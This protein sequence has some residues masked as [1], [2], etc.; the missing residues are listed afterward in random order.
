M[1][2]H[3]RGGA[4]IAALA[5][6]A[7]LGHALLPKESD[8]SSS[9]NETQAHR[10][11]ADKNGADKNSLGA[12]FS[13]LSRQVR[14]YD[15]RPS[16]ARVAPPERFMGWDATR[17]ASHPAWLLA[18][19]L[20]SGPGLPSAAGVG[21]V[22]WSFLAPGGG[23]D[24]SGLGS[25][26]GY[27]L[28]GPSVGAFGGAALWSGLQGAPARTV[29]ASGL[30]EQSSRARQAQAS[31][32]TE[33]VRR[34]G[35]AREQSRDQWRS[36]L[37]S[38]LRDE[39][40]LARRVDPGLLEPYV[41]TP[42]QAA[43]LIN[44]RL[45]L[46][47]TLGTS[48]A[49]KADAQSERL[50]LENEIRSLLREQELARRGVLDRLRDVLPAQLEAKRRDELATFL[51]ELDAREGTALLPLVEQ[52]RERIARDFGPTSRL[53]IVL[54]AIAA[55]PEAQRN[56][57][58]SAAGSPSTRG[59][60]GFTGSGQWARSIEESGQGSVSLSREQASF[61]DLGSSDASARARDLARADANQWERVARRRQQAWKKLGSGGTQTRPAGSA[62][63][64]GI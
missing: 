29:L 32:L 8:L 34:A 35:L 36:S 41:P 18:S 38:A 23:V 11:G 12:W 40:E 50:A 42:E 64:K 22:D 24:I 57:S 31:A 52:Q 56:S 53:G 54:P 60:S 45:R 63:A 25:S 27:T 20:D 30:E 21:A 7:A 5:L 16:A 3:A 6:A 55:L 19:R 33:F 59:G 58:G 61:P 37:E 26:Q 4:G 44:L 43:R 49:Q 13:E 15:A 51:R 28:G 10:T 9:V 14:E 1:M 62:A 46:L 48:N 47:Q 17:T 2:R 39:L